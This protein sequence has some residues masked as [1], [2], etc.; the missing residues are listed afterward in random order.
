MKVWLAK[1][2]RIEVT[3]TRN[4][5]L[6][7]FMQAGW[8]LRER[9]GVSGSDIHGECESCGIPLIDGP[10]CF[11]PGPFLLCAPCMEKVEET[12]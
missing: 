4:E 6:Q 2:V 8:E 12:Q 1:E 7:G 5:Q 10:G 11:K 3:I 9:G